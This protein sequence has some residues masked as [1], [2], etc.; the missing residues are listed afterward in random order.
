[1]VRWALLDPGFVGLIV[2]ELKIGG[3]AQPNFTQV[4]GA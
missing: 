4:T 2:D 1:V 3:P